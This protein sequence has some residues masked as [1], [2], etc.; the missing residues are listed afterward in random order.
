[1]II[2]LY[3]FKVYICHILNQVALKLIMIKKY[4]ILKKFYLKIKSFTNLNDNYELHSLKTLHQNS[5]V[6]NNIEPYRQK[7]FSVFRS[8]SISRY[9]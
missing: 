8:K 3:H 2:N 7:C 6:R 5:A 9:L 1:M 4:L